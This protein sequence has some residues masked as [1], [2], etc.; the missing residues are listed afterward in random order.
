M[1]RQKLQVYYAGGYIGND[2]PPAESEEPL[3]HPNLQQQ[4]ADEAL[5]KANAEE[6]DKRLQSRKENNDDSSNILMYP[7]S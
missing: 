4:E 2:R 5:R 3:Q 6:A 7:N 1:K